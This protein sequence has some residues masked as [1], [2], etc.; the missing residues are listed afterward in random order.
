MLSMAGGIEGLFNFF[1]YD[2]V[3]LKYDEA[4]KQA[5]IEKYGLLTYEDYKDLLPYELYEVLPCQYMSVSIGKG[6]IT[7]DKVKEYI[8]HWSDQLLQ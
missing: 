8:N 4:K 7:W 5:D 3:T 6:L 2:P 1:D